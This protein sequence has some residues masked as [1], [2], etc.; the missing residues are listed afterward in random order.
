MLKIEVSAIKQKSRRGF[1]DIVTGVEEENQ[2]KKWQK[3]V[4]GALLM[5]GMIIRRSS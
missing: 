5:S 2:G 1:Q 3:K 4:E